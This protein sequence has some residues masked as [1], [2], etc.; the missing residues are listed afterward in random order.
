MVTAGVDDENVAVAERLEHRTLHA[1]AERAREVFYLYALQ[2]ALTVALCVV[3]GRHS[4][5]GLTASVSI[6]YS[7]AAV[8]ALGALARHHVHIAAEIWSRHVRRSF[9]ASLVAALVM[10][11]TYS[12]FSWTRGA[13]LLARFS[14]AAV[15]GL[16][17]YTLVVVILQRRVARVS[18][19]DARLN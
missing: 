3:L 9:V 17:S 16:V 15:L 4:I 19:K 6:A 1:H 18:L 13:G 8:V 5:A 11:L 2:N 12:A 14:F 10:A 7:A